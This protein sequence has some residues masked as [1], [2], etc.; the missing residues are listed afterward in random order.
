MATIVTTETM[1]EGQGTTIPND[2]DN[3]G[4]KNNTTQGDGATDEDRDRRDG[5][6]DRP[7]RCV[8]RRLGH[9]YCFS[10][11]LYTN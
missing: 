10:C 1:G 7:K 8:S 2:N 6:N 5:E 4:A 11:F 9:K 3:T